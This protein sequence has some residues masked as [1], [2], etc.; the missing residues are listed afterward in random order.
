MAN[1]STHLGI[2]VGVDG[3]PGS[4]IAIQWAAHDA[5]LRDV[6][7]TLVHAARTRSQRERGQLVLD[8]A[9]RIVGT[10][11]RVRCEMPCATAVFALADLSEHAELVVVGCLG[12]GAPQRRQLC[13]LSS[14]LIHHARC[15]VVV[16]HDDVR[17]TSESLAAPVLVGNDGSP[18]AQSAIAIAF[19]EAAIRGVGLIAVQALDD[20]GAAELLAGWSEHYP[21]VAVQQAV[22]RDDPTPELVD[23]ARTAQLV[24]VGSGGSS[25]FAEMLPGSDGAGLAL[26]TH[27]P[28]IVAR[29]QLARAR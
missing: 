4:D 28:V 14:T 23:G 6:P 27:V 7:L 21:D 11:V 25:G 29:A 24:V 9:L 22:T 17:L 8:E 19:N 16:V 2:V 15:P 5:A 1:R 26:L 12:A 20:E 3:S 10:Q 13:S 18:E